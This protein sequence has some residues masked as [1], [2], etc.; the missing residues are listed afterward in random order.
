MAIEEQHA[1]EVA[2]RRQSSVGLA[3]FST[4]TSIT[5][6]VLDLSRAAFATR[7]SALAVDVRRFFHCFALGTTVLALWSR[8]TTAIGM[9]TLDAS[10]FSHVS[11]P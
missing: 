7:M 2:N 8:F 10:L 6:L 5:R 11:S 1:D 4:K 3:V 9:R